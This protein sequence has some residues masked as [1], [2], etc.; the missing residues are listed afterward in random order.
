[1]ERSLKSKGSLVN[2]IKLV[3]TLLLISTTILTHSLFEV[4]NSDKVPQLHRKI[5]ISE[6]QYSDHSTPLVISPNEGQTLF[7]FHRGSLADANENC[8]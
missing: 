4:T 8:C 6:D 2:T 1:M 3:M 5:F 7:R